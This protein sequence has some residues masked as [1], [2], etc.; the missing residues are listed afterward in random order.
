MEANRESYCAPRPTDYRRTDRCR[1]S[2][3]RE[4]REDEGT[5]SESQQLYKRERGR[6][7]EAL[8]NLV[9]LPST[10]RNAF[11]RTEPRRGRVHRT[12]ISYSR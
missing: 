8:V 1:V 9:R 10:D 6:E 11:H 7:N 3:G 12:Y 4:E 5:Y 2:R